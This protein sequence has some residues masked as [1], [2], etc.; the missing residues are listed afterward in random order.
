MITATLTLTREL[1]DGAT[2]Y[3]KYFLI[4][5]FGSVRG[6][7]NASMVQMSAGAPMP[8]SDQIT[9]KGGE[10]EAMLAAT[11]LIRG[12][13]ENQGYAAEVNLEPSN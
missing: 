9:V 4:A 1:D 12:L 5:D 7:G 10:T 13:A 11:D 6:E 3:R 8:D 2:G